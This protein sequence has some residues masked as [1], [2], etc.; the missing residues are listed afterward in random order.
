[1]HR[2]FVIS[3]MLVATSPLAAAIEP[4]P[5]VAQG[6]FLAGTPIAYALLDACGNGELT[7]GVDSNCAALPA[8]V[9][10]RAYTLRATDATGTMLA[11]SACFYSADYATVECDTPRVP[12]WAARVS[13][14]A[15]GG[16][17]VRWRFIA[18][19]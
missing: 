9:G 18:N 14:S 17:E 10:G 16:G 3:A 2:M 19:A 13:I 11:A 7:Q 6:K 12:T 15:L 8:T 5:F 1:M 4:T